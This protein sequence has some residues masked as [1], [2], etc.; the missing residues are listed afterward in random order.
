MYRRLCDV[1]AAMWWGGGPFDFS[2]SP[3]PFGLDF[4]TL[5]IRLRLDNNV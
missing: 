2:V 4:E 5:D 3:S 1:Q